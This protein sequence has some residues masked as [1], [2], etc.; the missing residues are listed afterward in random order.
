MNNEQ[1]TIDNEGRKAYGFTKII[2][3]KLQSDFILNWSQ[4][5]HKGHKL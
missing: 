5:T 2:F 3:K 4:T 1:L